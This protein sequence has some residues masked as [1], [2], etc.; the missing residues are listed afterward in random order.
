MGADVTGDAYEGL[1]ERNAQDI[2]S[3][4]GQYFTPRHLIGAMV[5]SAAS[6]RPRGKT[7]LNGAAVH[8]DMAL[9]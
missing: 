2:K 9:A 7:S 3:G 8:L 6:A 4:T 5:D 1:L